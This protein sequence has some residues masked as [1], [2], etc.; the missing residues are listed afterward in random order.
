MIVKEIKIT[1]DFAPITI[2]ITIE[3]E[4]E[5]KMLWHRFNINITSIINSPGYSG[6]NRYPVSYS[7][8]DILDLW[9]I[10]NNRL[11]GLDL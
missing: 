1:P 5:L 3:S 6:T 4:E 11:T 2:E 9:K 8:C 7:D 10:I